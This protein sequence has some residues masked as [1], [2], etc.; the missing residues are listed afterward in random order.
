[1]G[2]TIYP[3]SSPRTWNPSQPSPLDPV[4]NSPSI[5]TQ[6]ASILIPISVHY[7]LSPSLSPRHQIL[8]KP[9][10]VLKHSYAAKHRKCDTL[11][12]SKVQQMVQCRLTCH[13]KERR[14]VAML[15]GCSTA[16]TS[17][18]SDSLMSARSRLGSFLFVLSSIAFTTAGLP[19]TT[20]STTAATPQQGAPSRRYYRKIYGKIRGITDVPITVQLSSLGER[21]E[22]PQLG[23]RRT[24]AEIELH[25]LFV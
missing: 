19:Q 4:P 25:T 22:L 20:S 11:R 3:H 1:M 23:P 21:C 9:G 12:S 24:P 15:N 7:S 14:L 10:E 6:T 18:S 8:P 17:T 2:M 13:K 16:M 5:H